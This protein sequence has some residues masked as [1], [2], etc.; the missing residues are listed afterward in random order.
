MNR[1]FE[2]DLIKNLF[3]KIQNQ[4]NSINNK[5]IVYL[6]KTKKKYEHHT[7]H[8]PNIIA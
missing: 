4:I 5:K 7:A 3:L 2:K 8:G 1:F 6:P